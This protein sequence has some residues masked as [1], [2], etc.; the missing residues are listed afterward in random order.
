M[1]IDCGSHMEESSFKI[2]C[3]SNNM[4]LKRFSE[5]FNSTSI[6]TETKLKGMQTLF[7]QKWSPI[8]ISDY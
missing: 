1:N 8:Q 7:M 5:I 2:L 3:L 4:N 6:D